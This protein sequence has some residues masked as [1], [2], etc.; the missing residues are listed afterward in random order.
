MSVFQGSPD[1]PDAPYPP[2]FFRWTC[3]YCLQTGEVFL[4]PEQPWIADDDNH[5]EHIAGDHR[6]ASPNC[7]GGPHLTCVELNV[8]GGII[9]PPAT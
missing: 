8:T 1:Y 9:A 7:P 4:Q 5:A 2:R 3:N 6:K